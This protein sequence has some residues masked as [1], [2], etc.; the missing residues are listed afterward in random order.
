MS[1]GEEAL[2]L[3]K[4]EWFDLIL[5]DISMPGMG[6]IEMTNQIRADTLLKHQPYIVA[7]TANAMAG[8]TCIEAGMNDY[9][10][11]PFMPADID[12]ILVAFPRYYVVPSNNNRLLMKIAIVQT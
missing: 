2:E 12:R 10:S 4:S 11:K 5:M 6:G 7:L 1:S 8:E 3:P 9:I